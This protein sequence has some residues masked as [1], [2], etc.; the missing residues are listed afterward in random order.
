[1]RIIQTPY[2]DYEDKNRLFLLPAEKM[3]HMISGC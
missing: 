1:M 3:P 2:I